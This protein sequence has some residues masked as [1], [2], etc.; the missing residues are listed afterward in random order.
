MKRRINWNEVQKYYDDGNSV[1]EILEKFRFNP[2]ALQYAKS[3]GWFKCTRKQSDSLILHYKKYGIPTP[4]EEQKERVSNTIKEKVKQGKWHYS[5]SK[6]RSHKFISKYAGEV[7]LMGSWE[8]KFAEYLD[9]NNIPWRRPKEKFYYE[10]LSLRKGFGY[11]IPDFYLIEENRYIE[12]KGYETDK[13]RAKWK[14]FPHPLEIIKGKDLKER[15][16]IDIETK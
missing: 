15:F 12:I 9:N 6:V 5:F 7:M 3:K 16:K 2:K 13:D 11:Y 14:W 10:Y 1:K 4:S 8:L